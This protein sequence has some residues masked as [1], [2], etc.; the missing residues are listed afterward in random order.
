MY[1]YI[2]PYVD[3]IGP[4]QIAD[5]IFFWTEKYPLDEKLEER[6]DYKL[7]DR[8]G[9][10]LNS[11]WVK[12][13]CEWVHKRKQR[14][15]DIHVDGYDVWSADHTLGLIILPVLK[16][17][18]EVKHGSPDIDDE[19]VPEE[20]KSTSAPPKKHEYDTD[21]NFHKRW[22]W[23]LDEMIWAF[24]QHNDDNADDQFHSGK[25]ETMWQKVNIETEE[26]IGDP[27]P[28][29]DTREK[30]SPEEKDNVFYT[31]VKGPN[32]THVFDKEGWEKWNARKQNGFKLF[33]KYFTALWD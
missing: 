21:D 12:K 24:E 15:V 20:L 16:K 13:Y 10:W 23:V 3:W 32:D 30:L 25:H 26:N 11:T 29:G 4:Y 18:K 5:K 31:M 28:L 14:A 17:L 22:D 1:V 9:D 6:W 7:K 8:F 27:I 19:D 2:G 33:G